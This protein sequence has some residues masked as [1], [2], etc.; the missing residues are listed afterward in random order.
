MRLVAKALV[1]VGP[2]SSSR[3]PSVCIYPDLLA[4]P[5]VIISNFNSQPQIIMSTKSR[6]HSNASSTSSSSSSSTSDPASFSGLFRNNPLHKADQFDDLT[7]GTTAKA[8]RWSGGKKTL[9]EGRS[10]F[11]TRQVAGDQTTPSRE[12]AKV[13]VKKNKDLP[14]KVKKNHTPGQAGKVLE[15]LSE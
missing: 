14:T 10:H 11:E 5:S 9:G 12:E 15:A 8:R 7:H 3:P 1:V 4:N 6:S 13:T 2:S